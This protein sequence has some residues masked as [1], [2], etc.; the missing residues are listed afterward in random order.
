MNKIISVGWLMFIMGVLFS[1]SGHLVPTHLFTN[2]DVFNSCLFIF[3]IWL[4][5]F[6]FNFDLKNEGG[7]KNARE[8]RTKNN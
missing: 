4:T 3:T 8:K 7:G 1:S 6:L 2:K 5:G